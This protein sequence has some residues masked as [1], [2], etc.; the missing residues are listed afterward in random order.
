MVAILH[1]AGVPRG[2]LQFLPG[3]GDVGA[4]LC[5][6]PDV[7]G[8]VFTGSTEVARLIQKQLAT[9]TSAT[10]GPIPLIAETGGINAMIV[11][12]SALTEQVATD[13]LSSAFDSAGQRCSALRLLCLQEDVAERTLEMLKGAMQ[14]LRTG[15]PD[16]LSTD[17]GPVISAEAQKRLTGHIEAMRAGGHAVTQAAAPSGLF[18]PP[19]IIEISSIDELPGE[20][21][22]PVLH[23]LRYPREGLDDVVRQAN[24][25]GFGLTFGVHSR[26]DETIERATGLSA[27]GNQYVNRTVIGAVVGVQPFGGHGLSGTGPKAGGP[28]YV[29]RLLSHCPPLSLE[30]LVGELAG[31]VGERNEYLLRAKGTILCVARDPAELQ[32]QADAARASGNRATMDP[33]DPG[34]AAALFAG[35][36]DDLLALSRRL[37]ERDG[38]IVPVH[39]APYPLEFLVDEVSLSVNTAAAGGNASLMTIG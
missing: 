39:L 14:E 10:G 21:F 4:A 32:V 5:A 23:V 19:T 25:T 18:V 6:H 36:R 22:G 20:V 15:N 11:D 8:V 12:S 17:V 27:A 1:E 31:P 24:A 30:S 28:L 38:P 13:V 37:A 26:I 33:D 2:A 7:A 35:S 29:R 34:I 16:R 9:R 3:A